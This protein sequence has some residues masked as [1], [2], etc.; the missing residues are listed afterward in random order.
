MTVRISRARLPLCVAALS[1]G[2]LAAA[3]AFAQSAMSNNGTTHQTGA[4]MAPSGS[5]MAPSQM[6]P[7]S[8]HSGMMGPG[9]SHSGMSMSHDQMG[10]PGDMSNDA[11]KKHGNM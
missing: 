8:D 4:A 9:T 7:T 6:S 3:P 10:H 1:L 11:Q 2:L 5:H